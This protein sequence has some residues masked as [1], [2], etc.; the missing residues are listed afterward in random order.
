MRFLCFAGALAQHNRICKHGRSEPK[1][2]V[3][4]LLQPRKKV[5]CISPENQGLLHQIQK[6]NR[7]A[8]EELPGFLL[9]CII[10]L[11]KNQ[12]KT[13]C[14]SRSVCRTQKSRFPHESASLEPG[15]TMLGFPRGPSTEGMTDYQFK[16]VIRMVMTIIKDSESKE[17]ILKKPEALLDKVS[18][19]T[20]YSTRTGRNL[21][22]HFR[23]YIV[24]CLA[25]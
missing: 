13:G 23:A 16:T 2:S 14:P 12:Q 9:S 22:P 19:A 18:K 5:C 10:N 21:P 17:E 1:D 7:A 4:L 6:Q 20:S 25:P 11:H 8:Q 24:S 3:K 15:K